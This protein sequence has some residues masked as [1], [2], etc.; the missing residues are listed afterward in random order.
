MDGVAARDFGD[1][2]DGCRGCCR[3]DSHGD[4]GGDGLGGVAEVGASGELQVK[5]DGHVAGP[6]Q[7]GARP[8]GG[9]FDVAQPPVGGGAAD[10]VGQLLPVEGGDQVPVLAAANDAAAAGVGGGVAAP[11]GACGDPHD[12]GVVRGSGDDEGVVAVGDH[13]GVRV[14]GGARAQALFDRADFADAVELVAREVEV[15][16]DVGRDVR[17]DR[18]HVH[19]VDFEGGARGPLA[20]HEGGDDA[21]GHVVAIDVGGDGSGG[22]EGGADHARRRGLAVRSGDDDGGEGGRQLGEEL[23]GDAQGDLPANHAS[24]SAPEGPGGEAG[25]GAGRVGHARADREVMR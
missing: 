19:F 10:E 12:A 3:V 6:V 20:L 25:G 15:D 7:E 13:D 5:G 11:S 4:R 24:G 21:G 9:Q 8:L 22:F 18:G 2:A 17:S 14:R 23:R 16:E 1:G